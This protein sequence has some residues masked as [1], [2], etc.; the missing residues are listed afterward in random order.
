MK[1]HMLM[2]TGE[3]PHACDIYGLHFRQAQ[4]L[5][6]LIYTGVKSHDCGVCCK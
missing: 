1:E 6:E 2:H 4:H 3:K 5:K